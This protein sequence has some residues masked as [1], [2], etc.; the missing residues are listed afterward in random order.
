MQPSI[1]KTLDAVHTHANNE[2]VFGWDPMPGIVSA[3]AQRNGRAVVWRREDAHIT[4]IKETFRPWLFAATLD[5]LAHLG[6]ALTASPSTERRENSAGGF[7]ADAAR[8]AV[9]ANV[10][11]HAVTAVALRILLNIMTLS[12]WPGPPGT[13]SQSTRV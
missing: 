7:W 2:L 5:D 11:A 12:S 4:C 13:N 1:S 8:E 9:T 6:S 3:W 10:N